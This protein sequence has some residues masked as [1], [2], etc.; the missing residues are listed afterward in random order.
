MGQKGKG[1]ERGREER[2]RGDGRVASWLLGGLTPLYS[3]QGH[4]VNE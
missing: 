3:F 4:D 1:G 2:V